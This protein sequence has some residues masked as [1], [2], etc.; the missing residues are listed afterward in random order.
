MRVL[1]TVDQSNEA[2]GI[3]PAT[4]DK[5]RAR[6]EGKIAVRSEMPCRIKSNHKT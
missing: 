4:T 2:L 5:I 6:G 1:R 3:A